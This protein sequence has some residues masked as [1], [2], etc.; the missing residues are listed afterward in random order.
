[1]VSIVM[2]SFSMKFTVPSNLTIFKDILQKTDGERR[3]MRRVLERKE[4]SVGDRE[5]QTERGVA[6]L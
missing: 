2:V 4:G 1:M 6:L 3:E 5:I